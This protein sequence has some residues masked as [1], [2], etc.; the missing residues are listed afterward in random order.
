[1]SSLNLI[2]PTQLYKNYIAKQSVNF[3]LIEDSLIFGCDPEWPLKIH[4]KKI[5]LHLASMNAYKEYLIQKG[6]NVLYLKH[7]RHK[8]T[9][10]YLSYLYKLGYKEFIL[11]DPNDNVLLKRIRTFCST[12]NINL[13]IL[14]NPSIL[15]SKELI[16]QYSSTEKKP[17]MKNFYK[18]QRV[19]LNILIDNKNKPIGDKWSFDLENRK[20]LPKSIDLPTITKLVHNKHLIKAINH[21][22]DNY[23]DYYGENNDFNL[24]TTHAEAEDWLDKFIEERLFSFGAYEDAIH[25][26][27]NTLWH[28]L[29]S[30]LLNIGLLTP[31]LI[32]KRVINNYKLYSIPLNSLEG[33]IRQ[34]IGWRE[35]MSIMYNAHGTKMRNSNFWNFNNKKIPISF[36]NGTTGIEPL[37]DSINNVLRTGYCHHIERLMIIGNF[38]L[39]CRFHPDSVYKWFME[40]FIDAYDWVMVPNVYGMSQFSDGGIFTTKPYISGSNYIRKMSDYKVG[41]WSKKWDGL[42][43][44][45]I[46]D[47]KSFFAKQNRLSILVK[48]LE[49][50]NDT[51]RHSHFLEAN[52]FLSSF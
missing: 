13:I 14:D 24:P 41:E 48:T 16:D 38:M 43:W 47:Y 4:K 27:N 5:T 20:K 15:T 26:K 37:D 10:H 3:V 36:Y 50:M 40:L 44:L 49:K 52:Q 17:F 11:Y 31:D 30:P 35:F 29:L 34:I 1:M 22:N 33:L 28:S 23:N 32:I 21:V 8:K 6:F 51:K 9:E 2:F 42:F 12:F 45:F 39:L 7:E 18:K 25:K 19:H 46:N